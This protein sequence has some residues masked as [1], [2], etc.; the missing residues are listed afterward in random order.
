MLL[1][2]QI[3]L[4]EAPLGWPLCPIEVSPQMFECF[5]SFGISRY[6]RLTLVFFLPQPWKKPFVCGDL[7]SQG[8]L[9]RKSS[10]VLW[11]LPGWSQCATEIEDSWLEYSK[12][13]PFVPTR[14]FPGTHCLLMLPVMLI[15]CWSLDFRGPCHLQVGFK[16][17]SLAL[18]PE[19]A[20][21]YVCWAC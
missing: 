15:P 14:H 10:L 4:V 1:L 20:T 18:P 8:L 9:F 13:R 2:S 7:V 3:L 5:I 6:S 21:P 11:K 19:S 16:C 12:G 17:R